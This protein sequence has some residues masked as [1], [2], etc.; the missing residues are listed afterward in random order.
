VIIRIT[1]C[2]GP[3]GSATPGTVLPPRRIELFLSRR[4]YR[5]G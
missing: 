2:W 4:P 5:E 1:A 3:L